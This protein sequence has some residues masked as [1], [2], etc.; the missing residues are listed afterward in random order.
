[1][2]LKLLGNDL[3]RVTTSPIAELGMEITDIKGGEGV[4]TISEF[5]FPR[6]AGEGG[7]Y[8]KF[9]ST[10]VFDPH[11]TYRY[12]KANGANILAGDGV[13]ADVAAADV[14]VPHFVLETSAAN[15]ICE[16]VTMAAIPLNSFG[17]IQTK[18]KHFNVQVADAVAD[19]ADLDTGANGVFTVAAALSLAQVNSWLS[20]VKLVKIADTSSLITGVV[21]RGI[22]ML[23]S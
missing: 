13:R 4:L 6:T 7:G 18:G 15:Q 20:G 2:S 14:S 5:L 17:W 21:D 3:F 23:R 12:V 11:G 16:G 9:T 8:G 1:V 19:D 10:R 22:C